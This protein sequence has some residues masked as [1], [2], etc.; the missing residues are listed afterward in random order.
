VVGLSGAGLSIVLMKAVGL[1]F[2]GT[3]MIRRKTVETKGI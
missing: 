2:L 1:T 3:S